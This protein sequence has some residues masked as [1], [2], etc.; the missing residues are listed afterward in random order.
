M[1]GTL[2]KEDE[3]TVGKVVQFAR[4]LLAGEKAEKTG[5]I[6]WKRANAKLYEQRVMSEV[7]E[8]NVAS[9]RLDNRYREEE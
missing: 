8:L 1:V 2:S 6:L 9:R 4:G 5:A 7:M 3:M